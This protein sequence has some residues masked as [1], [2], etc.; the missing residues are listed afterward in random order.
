MSLPTHTNRYTG[1]RLANAV[2]VCPAC[3]LNFASTSAGDKHRDWTTG[4][5]VC[6]EP[7]LAGLE[8]FLNTYGAMLWRVPLK[9]SKQVGIREVYS[10]VS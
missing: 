8:P 3:R 7:S 9:T 2:E 10:L 5:G 1:E 6:L 4:R